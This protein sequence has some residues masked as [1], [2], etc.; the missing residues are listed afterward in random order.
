M[1][2]VLRCIFV[3]V[4]MRSTG[5]DPREMHPLSCRGSCVCGCGEGVSAGEQAMSWGG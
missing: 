2:D 5:Q 1:S 3:P 4:R